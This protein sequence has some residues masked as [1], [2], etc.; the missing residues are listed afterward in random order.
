ML[1][2]LLVTMLLLSGLCVAF[3]LPF[4]V[5]LRLVATS[6]MAVRSTVVTLGFLVLRSCRMQDAV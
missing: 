3:M 1:V 5:K 6:V 2:L 4:I